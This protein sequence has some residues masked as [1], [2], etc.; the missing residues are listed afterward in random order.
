[1]KTKLLFLVFVLFF[2]NEMFAQTRLYEFLVNQNGFKTSDVETT[3]IFYAP[4]GARFEILSETQEEYIIRFKYI[5]TPN[6]S[7]KVKGFIGET[8]LIKGISAEQIVHKDV[9]YKIGIT[10]LPRYNYRLLFGLDWGALT[11]PF[12]L[13][14]KDGVLSAGSSIGPYIGWKQRWIFGLPSTLVLSAGLSI[15][16]TQDVNATSIDTKTGLTFASGIVFTPVSQLQIGI[17]TGLDHLGGNVGKNY[18]YENKL[19]ISFAIGFGFT[20]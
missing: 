11:V 5:P 20:K 14:T 13:Q 6:S 17:I 18:P 15:I 19:W 16:P 3:D 8:F 1:M 10:N 2:A 4:I 9:N 12:K 7:H